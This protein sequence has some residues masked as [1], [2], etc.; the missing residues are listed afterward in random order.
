MT[1]RAIGRE[2]GS[3]VIGICRP[4]EI[5]HVARRAICRRPRKPAIHMAL[6]TLQAHMCT[7]QREA[8]Q[9]VVELRSQPR[10][11]RVAL[12]ARYRES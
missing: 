8:C 12:L 5:R 11:G 6:R 4:V 3:R 10:G 1:H 2:P 9:V 7:R